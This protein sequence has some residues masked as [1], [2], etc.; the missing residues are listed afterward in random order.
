MEK[1]SCLNSKQE[2]PTC[3]DTFKLLG[4]LGEVRRPA[5]YFCECGGINKHTP[6][7]T[8]RDAKRAKTLHTVYA[9]KFSAAADHKN[10]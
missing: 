5:W 9:F 4:R 1:L 2:D 8:E 7:D 3:C 10:I 6:H